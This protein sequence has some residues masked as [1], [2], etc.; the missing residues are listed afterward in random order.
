[1][2]LYKQTA[3]LFA[4][5]EYRHVHPITDQQVQQQTDVGDEMIMTGC[6]IHTY[7]YSVIT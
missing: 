6:A 2:L 4:G 5:D 1:M 7:T 3:G